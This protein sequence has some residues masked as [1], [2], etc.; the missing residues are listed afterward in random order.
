[1]DYTFDNID[2]FFDGLNNSA[3]PTVMKMYVYAGYKR[4]LARMEDEYDVSV[5]YNSGYG[6]SYLATK[7]TDD[8]FVV[9]ARKGGDIVG[10]I[11]H[12]LG[13]NNNGNAIYETFDKAVIA[14]L[15]LKYD[16]KEDAAG[17][18]FRMIGV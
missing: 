12:V 7:V 5:K 18:I 4:D 13:K 9:V 1:M 17:Y 2:E 8:I 10:Y 3:N 14:A 16:G 6:Y 11:P 15:C